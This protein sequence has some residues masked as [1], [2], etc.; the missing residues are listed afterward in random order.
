MKLVQSVKTRMW[1]LITIN[2]LTAFASIWV[3]M[4]MAPA[5]EII[6]EQNERSLRA[7]EGMLAC[8]ALLNNSEEHAKQIQTDFEKALQQAK[9]NV[10]EKGEAIA[11]KSI[12]FNYVQ[13]LSGNYESKK[14]LVEA[15]Q[16]LSEANRN[17]MLRADLKARNLGNAGAWGIVFMASL[18]FT[19][20]LFFLRFLRKNLLAPIEEINSVLQAVKSGDQFRRCTGYEAPQG[21][22][23]IFRDL[24]DILDQKIFNNCS[25]K[26]DD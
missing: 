3:F 19:I 5:I 9:D 26:A 20:T 7:C 11:I 22:R 6:I 17:A 2:L 25:Y 24:N 12:N 21:I 13:A 18:V 23:S 10:T 4:R 8:L 16:K 14:A 15:I 1:F